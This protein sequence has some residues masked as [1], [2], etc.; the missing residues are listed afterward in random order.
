M[1]D[2]TVLV[3]RLRALPGERPWWWSLGRCRRWCAGWVEGRTYL[4]VVEARNF[5]VLGY[6]AG[7]SLPARVVPRGAFW[8]PRRGT[9]A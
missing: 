4:A 9:S 3:L 1:A 8:T 2:R 6:D 5:N 7:A